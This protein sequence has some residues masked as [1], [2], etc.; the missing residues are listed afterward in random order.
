MCTTARASINIRRKY[1]NVHFVHCR[2][3]FILNDFIICV[4][5]IRRRM[6]INLNVMGFH[7]AYKIPIQLERLLFKAKLIRINYKT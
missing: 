1:C 3:V 2:D 6:H 5:I 4:H 7:C